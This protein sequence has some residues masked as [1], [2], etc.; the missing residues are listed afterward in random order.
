MCLAPC[1]SH[2]GSPHGRA[3][4]AGREEIYT[5]IMN[6]TE[7]SYAEAQGKDDGDSYAEA[8]GEDDDLADGIVRTFRQLGNTCEHVHSA[9]G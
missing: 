3:W 4:G 5:S 6:C 8:Q 7:D 9:Y 2:A 1:S